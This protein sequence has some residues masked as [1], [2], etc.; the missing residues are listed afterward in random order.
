[1]APSSHPPAPRAARSYGQTV[2]FLH[3]LFGDHG[4]PDAFGPAEVAEHP[5]FGEVASDVRRL[6]RLMQALPSDASFVRAQAL[7]QAY[8]RML[9]IAAEQLEVPNALHSLPFG[10]ERTA[11][12]ARVESGL[13]RAGLL[14]G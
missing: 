13:E 7:W 10:P 6:G 5:P 2:E 8:D 4:D 1:M 11:E 3:S 14:F 9:G 12:R